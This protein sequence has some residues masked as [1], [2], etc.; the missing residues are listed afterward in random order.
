MGEGSPALHAALAEPIAAAGVDQL[1]LA[2]PA[3]RALWEVLPESRRGAWRETAEA[4]AP[5]VLAAIRAGDIVMAKGSKG[6]K[7]SV[8][9]AAL[10]AAD[11]SNNNK[12]RAGGSA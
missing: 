9:V 10:L 4:L 12:K 2:G 3:M 11:L 5:E 8:V 1:F 7:A 6:S